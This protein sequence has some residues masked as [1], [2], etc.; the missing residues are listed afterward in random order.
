MIWSW[1]S[2]SLGAAS[3]PVA[4]LAYVWSR[5][6]LRLLKEKISPSIEDAKDK[7]EDVVEDVF[8]P[9]KDKEE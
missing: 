5:H 8:E 7:I 6:G 1:L 3:V 9:G 4:Y 2:F